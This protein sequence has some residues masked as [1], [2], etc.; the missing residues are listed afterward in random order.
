M[1]EFAVR[2]SL[3]DAVDS[4]D[5]DAARRTLV[6]RGERETRDKIFAIR[7]DFIAYFQYD[8]AQHCLRFPGK[9]L[10]ISVVTRL[11]FF[12]AQFSKHTL[13][14]FTEY[15]IICLLRRDAPT[16][17][18]FHIMTILLGRRHIL[19]K[20]KKTL[21]IIKYK[22]IWFFLDSNMNCD[23]QCPFK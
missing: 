17:I 23:I 22:F 18:D 21:W 10:T 11:F 4:H 19:K 3:A 14:I 20:R 15:M 5:K 7:F 6:P 2:S 12:L 8:D 13:L 16:P 9:N 1:V